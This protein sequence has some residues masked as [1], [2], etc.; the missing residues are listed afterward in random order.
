MDSK[1]LAADLQDY[2]V[3]FR[4]E[5]HEHPELS[6]K[7]FWTTD[8]IVKELEGMGLTVRRFDPT[9]ACADIVGG[10][11]GKT[12]ALRADID[13]LAVKEDTGLPFASKIDGVMHACGHDTHAAML[14]GAT[15]AL[16]SIKDQLAGTVRVIFQPAEENVT[17]ARML[18]KQGV[19]DG[20]D[21]IFGQHIAGMMPVG[22]M[23]TAAGPSAAASDHFVIKVHG[24]SCHGA[25]PNTGA[26][27]T[28]AAANIVCALQSIVSREIAPAEPAVVTVG[29]LVS[30][31]AKNIVS[32]EAEM[33]GTVR[34]FSRELRKTMPERIERIAKQVAAA[35]RC[36]AELD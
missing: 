7:E 33:G 24:K 12:V 1:K 10:K 29:Q 23:S 30:G 21:M 19:L 6:N 8:R 32:G 26:D 13:A 18:V 15:R 35:Y 3:A 34:T 4:R 28:L 31:T 14:M 25:M 20:V 16:V 27:A 2:V 22:A 9:G 5:L 36:T 11:P 17:G